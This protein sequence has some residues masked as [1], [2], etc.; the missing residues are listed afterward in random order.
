MTAD[1]EHLANEGRLT[2]PFP[3]D[4]HRFDEFNEVMLQE[5]KDVQR[6][7]LENGS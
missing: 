1:L 6:R 4:G 7:R 3:A 2:V 5:L